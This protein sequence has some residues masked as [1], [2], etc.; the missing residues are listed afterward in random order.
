MS[1]SSST[2]AGAN[3]VAKRS[4]SISGQS[5]R[6]DL[7]VRAAVADKSGETFTYQAEVLVAPLLASAV[8]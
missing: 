5:R 3:F 2:F 7:T 4:G 6:R 8:A 1:A